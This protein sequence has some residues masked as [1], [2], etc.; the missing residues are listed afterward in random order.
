MSLFIVSAILQ[1]SDARMTTTKLTQ[2]YLTNS[3]EKAAIGHYT[4]KW[5][6]DFS[7]EGFSISAIL[8][9]EVPSDHLSCAIDTAEQAADGEGG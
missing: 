4:E 2:G 1:K 5:L 6:K 8:A 7:E 9:L 3:T